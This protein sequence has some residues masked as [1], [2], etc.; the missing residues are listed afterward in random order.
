[1]NLSIPSRRFK[2]EEIFS[3][4]R[5]RPIRLEK[6]AGRALP[7]YWVDEGGRKI[8]KAIH[9]QKTFDGFI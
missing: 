9:T 3:G 5:V 7:S 4:A 1:M 2:P 6:W 8:G